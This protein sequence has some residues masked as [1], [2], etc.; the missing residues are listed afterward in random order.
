MQV[1]AQTLP[2]LVVC[3]TVDQLRGDYLS[4]LE[5]MMSEGG[6]KRLLRSGKVYQDVRFPIHQVN[7][8]SATAT[9]FTGTYPRVHGIESPEVYLPNKRVV[10]PILWDDSVQGS[11]TRDQYSPRSIVVSTLGDRLKE[12]SLGSALVYGI[13]PEAE[14]AIVS[15]GG[16]ADG[17]YWIDS[18]IGSWATSSYYPQMPATIEQYNRSASGPNKRLLSGT[19]QWK[20]LQSYST[21]E[22]SY[23]DWGASFNYRYGITDVV[24]YKQSPLVNEEV[25]N[26]AVRLME[27]AGYAQRKSPGLLAISYTVAPNGL[28]EFGAEDVD[29]YLRLDSQIERL[30]REL[31]RQIGLNNCL[32]TLSGTGYTSY[33]TQSRGKESNRRSVS[34]ERLNALANMYLTAL[35]GT[36]NWIEANRDGRVY[37]NRKFIESRKLDLNRLQSEVAN[38]LRSADGVGFSV[39]AHE[40]G[41]SS[42]RA[43]LILQNGINSR[44]VADVYWS[45]LPGWQ[46]DELAKNP[47]L[48]P[49]STA[50]PSPLIIMGTGIDPKTFDY[51]VHEATDVVRMICRVLRIRPPNSTY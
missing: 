26:M 4:E 50:I 6:L 23:S 41:S 24:R 19:M 21:P 28:A 5:P 38:F 10:H 11:Y 1:E 44:Y 30:L 45:L 16:L 25:T 49:R 17:A 20:P 46:V 51:P 43:H 22:I 39:A 8:V 2:R 40:I 13:A 47:Q 27:S 14:A 34:V 33:R 9:L 42:D 3:I 18:R 37:L 12:A 31:E 15:A 29:T 32:I 36:G 35:H 48:T 7:N